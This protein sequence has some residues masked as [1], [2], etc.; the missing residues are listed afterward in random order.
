LTSFFAVAKGADDIHMVYDG[1][2]SGLNDSIG[3]P[4][5][6][7]PTLETRLKALD[8]GTFM[9]NVDVGD[10]FLNFMLHPTL[11]ELAGVDLSHY[12]GTKGQSLWEAWQ[13][14]A[15]SVKL[16]PFQA[17]SALTVADEIIK[18]DHLDENNEF[19]LVRVRLN[20]PGSLDYDP[21][22]PWVSKVRANG[23]IASDLFTF[24]DDLRPIGS[25]RIECWRATRRLASIPNRLGIQD[26]PRKRRDSS[27]SPGAWSGSVI[28]ITTDGVCV[29]ASEDKWIK[30]K[31]MLVEIDEMLES[32]PDALPRKRLEQIQGFFIYVTR[33]YPCM[34]PYLIGLHMTIDSWRPN[35]KADGWRYTAA[36]MW[37]RSEAEDKL[38]DE[39]LYD[40]T[41][42]PE[43]V[44]AV[45]RFA[46]DWRA[47]AELMSNDKPLLQRVRVNRAMKAYY[48]FGDASGYGFGATI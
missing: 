23:K 21:S 42:A 18:G 33:T 15:M 43:M 29:L 22:S 34:V 17:V 37:L 38:E 36:E 10:C 3:V 8:E 41:D 11:R 4:C 27:Q 39:D 19:R 35:R 47:L 13:R 16:S 14:A 12:F 30:A 9:A 7:L 20:L 1:T 28:R 45:P 6:V 5:F 46:W 31:A 32:N 2:I 24:A 48:S 44:K 25:R 40:H 26:A